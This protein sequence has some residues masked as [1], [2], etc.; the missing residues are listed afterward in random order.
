ML[1]VFRIY[2]IFFISMALVV[3]MLIDSICMTS[4]L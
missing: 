1:L 2:L 3:M 4:V